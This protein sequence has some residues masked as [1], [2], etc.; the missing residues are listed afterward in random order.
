MLTGL[1]GRQRE[2]LTLSFKLSLYLP[3]S[4]F[5]APSLFYSVFS[6]CA[7]FLSLSFLT[8]FLYIRGV[9]SNSAAVAQPCPLLTHHLQSLCTRSGPTKR[10][11]QPVGQCQ[12]SLLEAIE[13]PM[14]AMDCDSAPP[15]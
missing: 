10:F 7:F 15:G 9:A 11:G 1:M 6:S 13:M 2:G 5:M 12:F 4:L 14:P 3:Y 8:F